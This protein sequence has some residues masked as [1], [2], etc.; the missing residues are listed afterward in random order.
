M[1]HLI[2][3]RVLYD[4][5]FFNYELY[6]AQGMHDDRL[7]R[8]VI[9]IKSGKHLIQEY[10]KL[11]KADI[12]IEFKTA[13]TI[14]FYLSH[15]TIHLDNLFKISQQLNIEPILLVYFSDL[16]GIKISKDA[17]SKVS[18]NFFKEVKMNYRSIPAIQ[19]IFVPLFKFFEGHQSD[20]VKSFFHFMVCITFDR[21]TDE[22]GKFVYTLIKD[23]QFTEKENLAKF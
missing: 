19:D 11:M 7:I 23:R 1:T 17:L 15:M 8:K 12:L 6:H 20:T 18:K 21:L 9:F 10:Y 3:E 5:E 13:N 16:C 4:R 14:S 2:R 22:H